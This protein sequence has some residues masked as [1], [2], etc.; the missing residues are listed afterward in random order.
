MS[1]SVSV[2]GLGKLGLCFAACCADRGLQTIG[3][4]IEESVIKAVNNGTAPIHEPGLAELLARVGGKG[5][6]ATLNHADAIHQADVTFVLVAT[7]SNADGS[8]SNRYVESALKKLASALRGSAKAYHTFVISSTVV[9]G[10]TVNTFIPLIEEYS[11][12]T[13]NKGF[14]VCYDPDFVALGNVL[15]GF[16]NP[17]LIVLGE[18]DLRAGDSVQAIHDR[19]CRNKPVLT[20]MSIQSAEVAK[21]ALNAYITVKIS[22][23]N[24]MANLCE[25]IPGADVDVITKSIGVDKRISPYYFRGGLSFGGTCFPRDTRAFIHISREVGI[26]ADLIH[27]VDNINRFQDDHLLHLVLHELSGCNSK[28]IGVL[29]LA[30]KVDTPVVT[31]SPGMKLTSELIKR[32]LE[33][34]A[35]D[36]LALENAHTIFN[37][38]IS[39]VSSA[40]EC[41]SKAR[42]SV[43]TTTSPEFKS[44]VEGYRGEAPITVID[45]WR[46]VDRTKLS[47][48]VTCISW[49]HYREGGLGVVGVTSLSACSAAAL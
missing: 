11:G 29:G 34:I 28:S 48:N 8:F 19:V 49:G 23:A 35:Y 17:E 41:I 10:S 36:P 42:V 25:R 44:A 6:R 4:D 9:P 24:T 22:F 26:S 47:K 2:V 7:P 13:V 20:R 3:V 21:V 32:D 14:G 46:V 5:L 43:L 1:V 27:A 30:F 12:R 16:L 18:S 33:V 38:N 40:E 31:E 15:H 37:D 39:Y 45:C